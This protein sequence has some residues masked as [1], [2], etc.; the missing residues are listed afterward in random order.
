MTDAKVNTSAAGATGNVAMTHAPVDGVVR[1]VAPFTSNNTNPAGGIN[2]SARDMAKWLIVQLDSGRTGDST[3]RVFTA[4]T[5]R[6]LWSMVTPMPIGTGGLAQLRPNFLGYALGFNVR[7]YRGHKFVTHTGGLPGYLSMVS[8]IPDMK[9]GV[10]VLTNQE[11][12]AAFQAIS[13]WILDQYLHATDVDWVARIAPPPANTPKPPPEQPIG[14]P[15]DSL[16]RPSLSLAGYAC[17]YTDAW[18]GDVTVMLE[19]GKLVLRMV[20]TPGLVGDLEHWQHDTFV[21]RWRDREMRADAYV[22]FALNPDGSIDQVKMR[23]FLESTDF[24]FD[25]QDLLLKRQNPN[26]ACER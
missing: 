16:S 26:V 5:T 8:L 11:S 6:Q 18:Y 9:L 7:D 19:R 20:P 21:A 12:G 15:R 24:S 10:S 17:R 2:A 13:Y 4:Q 14:P 22:T 3:T 25:F 23:K 1:P